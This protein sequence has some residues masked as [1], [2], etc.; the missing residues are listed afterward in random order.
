M[1]KVIERKLGRYKAY[2]IIP[3]PL[4][5]KSRIEIDPRPS[6]RCYLN[7][8]IHEKL[9]ILFPELSE[10]AINAAAGQLAELLWEN[11]YRKVAQ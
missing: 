10:R 8:L 11:N 5:K 4:S 9:H 1:T 2:G 7:T 6:P 3:A